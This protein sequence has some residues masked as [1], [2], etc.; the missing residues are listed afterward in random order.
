M[1]FSRKVVTVAIVGLAFAIFPLRFNAF[2]SVYPTGT[3]IY[4]PDK[5]WSGYVIYDTIDQQRAR[6]GRT[7]VKR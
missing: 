2:P 1:Y 6:W 7:S 3:T 5:A 4:N